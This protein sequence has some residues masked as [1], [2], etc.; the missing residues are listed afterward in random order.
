MGRGKSARSLE[1]VAAAREILAEIQPAT[2][3]AVC[4]RLFTMGLIASMSKNNTNRVSRQLTD[5]R[6]RGEQRA[7]QDAARFGDFTPREVEG[8]RG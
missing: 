2:V 7:L 6:E 3:R 1:L 8:D 4:Y 5:A